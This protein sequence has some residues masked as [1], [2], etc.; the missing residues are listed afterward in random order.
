V[1]AL[2]PSLATFGVYL[3]VRA[4]LAAMGLGSPNYWLYPGYDLE[5]DYATIFSGGIPDPLSLF[6]T[7]P[8]LKDPAG[9]FAPP[10]HHTL[11]LLT[12]IA[13]THF[14]P[15]RDRPLH[16]RGPEY[17]RAKEALAARCVA[18]AEGL[19]PGLGASIVC[20]EIGTPLTNESYSLTSDGAVYGLAKTP[21]QLALSG[22][23]VRR[24]IK[25]L[26]IAGPYPCHGVLGCM[27]SGLTVASRI[28]GR[29]LMR[30]V[31][32]GSPLG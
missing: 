26:H 8:T 22:T 1:Q 11:T 2:E 12:F 29:D 6:V 7:V 21:E 3:G 17:R 28:V 31:M 9:G 16:R 19:I 14:A 24:E 5:R 4:D 25:D 30:R 15:W 27:L 20:Q 32:T 13:Y 23:P 10:G 18:R